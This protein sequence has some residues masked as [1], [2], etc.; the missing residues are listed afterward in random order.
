MQKAH[1]ATELR[2]DIQR[3]LDFL[4]HRMSPAIYLMAAPHD[5]NGNRLEFWKEALQ[6]DLNEGLWLMGMCYMTGIYYPEESG[7]H[8]WYLEKNMPLSEQLLRKAA[9]RGFGPALLGLA[10]LYMGSDPKN[11]V[12]AVKCFSQAAA[13]G[14]VYAQSFLGDHYQAGLGV[15]K[16][17][18]KAAD[19]Y[20]KAA[21]QD[22]PHAQAMLSRCYREGVGLPRDP[23]QAFEW[24]FRA[25]NQGYTQAKYWLGLH[26]C[27]GLGV[28]KNLPEALRWLEEA[29]T[30]HEDARVALNSLRGIAR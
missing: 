29:A 9:N 5:K 1:L 15:P 18:A 24:C 12:E 2:G 25:A 19:C 14:S 6:A 22:E 30:Q 26:Y 7:D 10:F 11:P 4:G 21:N 8:T 27:D 20:S 17:D 23:K 13:Q 3:A 28:K 16:D